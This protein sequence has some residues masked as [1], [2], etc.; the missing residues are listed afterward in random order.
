MTRPGGDAVRRIAACRRVGFL[1][2]L[3]LSFA[4]QSPLRLRFGI[5]RALNINLPSSALRS[6]S[7]SLHLPSPAGRRE[8]WIAVVFKFVR[9]T[10]MTDPS[11][12][13]QY[14][15]YAENL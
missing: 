11:G 9:P 7:S 8:Q 5:C 13:T 1:R 14:E 6:F 15:V 2:F 3:P 10:I 4:P 12:S